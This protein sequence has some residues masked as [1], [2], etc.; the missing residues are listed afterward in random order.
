MGLGDPSVRSG[1]G[2]TRGVKPP[3]GISC[4]SDRVATASI[5]CVDTTPEMA[6]LLAALGTWPVG[7]E[8]LEELR[9]TEEG[10]QA[11]TWGWI[12]ESGELTGTGHRHAGEPPRGVLPTRL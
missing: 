12:M 3:G 6:R 1:F 9:A 10:G 11:R 5:S 2:F 7:P 8:L 4:R